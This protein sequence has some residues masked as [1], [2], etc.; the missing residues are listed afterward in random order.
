MFNES[1][2]ITDDILDDVQSA[3][4][5]LAK[6]GVRT[7]E[8]RQLLGSLKDELMRK[9][10]ARFPGSP[11]RYHLSRVGESCL[12]Q[13]PLN[14]RGYLSKFRGEK[15]RIVCVGSGRHFHRDYMVGIVEP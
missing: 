12:Y 9:G 4:A 8:A 1:D 6:I 14:R 15:I 13:V 5:D 11:K 10:Y 2:K 3:L 7:S